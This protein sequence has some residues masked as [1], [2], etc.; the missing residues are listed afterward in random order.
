MDSADR[1]GILGLQQASKL[2]AP[3][4]LDWRQHEVLGGPAIQ[5]CP[6]GSRGSSLAH[7]GSS[8]KVSARPYLN[9]LFMRYRS[10]K[11]YKPLHPFGFLDFENRAWTMN[12]A[13]SK[14]VFDGIAIGADSYEKAYFLAFCSRSS[15]F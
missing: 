13:S 6:L 4:R 8:R 5:P 9:V 11:F 14:E 12:R 10:R 1:P 2:P 7:F 3:G 15:S